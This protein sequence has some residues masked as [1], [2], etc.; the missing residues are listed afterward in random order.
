[1]RPSWLL[2]FC[3][4]LI[5]SQQFQLPKKIVDQL[6]LLNDAVFNNEIKV[7]TR[8]NK[9]TFYHTMN[10]KKQYVAPTM[11]VID[12]ALEQGIAA[13]SALGSPTRNDNSVQEEWQIDADDSRT[14][15]W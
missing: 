8:I 9:N 15:N 7:T 12:L 5:P 13:G 3:F 14:I 2:L 11:T 6:F 4:S 10:N 1:M